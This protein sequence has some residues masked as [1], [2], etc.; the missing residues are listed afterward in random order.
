MSS[1]SPSRAHAR[2]TYSVR[3][4]LDGG[5]LQYVQY[6]PVTRTRG[7]RQPASQKGGVVDGAPKG[8]HKPGPTPLSAGS[9]TEPGG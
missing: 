8:S 2:G 6:V 1:G 9:R 3:S 4:A 7:G 5:N